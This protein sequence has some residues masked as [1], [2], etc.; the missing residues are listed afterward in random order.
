MK[1]VLFTTMAL[2]LFYTASADAADAEK[3]LWAA[4]I[5][6]G[7]ATLPH[8]MGSDERYTFAAPIPYIIYRGER[9]KIG[10]EGITTEL[11]GRHNL[12][13]DASLGIGLPVRNSNR[14]RAGMPELKFNFQAGPRLNWHVFEDEQFK[15]TVR[16]PW[17][18][19]M[20]TGGSWLGS[21]S[22][23]DIAFEYRPNAETLLQL[24]AGALFGSRSYH[25]TYYSVAPL[26]ATPV[27][28]VYQSRAGL[29]SLSLT[30]LA[31]YRLNDSMT[32]FSALRYRNLASG[33]IAD[34]PLVKDQNY[35]SATIGLAWSFW[36]SDEK[37]TRSE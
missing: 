34:S 23:P 19:V 26:Y 6:V 15:V 16:L 21:V 13:L 3:P 25:D 12:T 5:A 8:Y 24:N 32:L 22:E 17:R 28:P 37:S 27:R 4:G 31:R 1:K 33:V 10:R 11:F 9:V 2:L 29:H 7:A 18:G 35:L 14:A 36:Q 20:D 30:A